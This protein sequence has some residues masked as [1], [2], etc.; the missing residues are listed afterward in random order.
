MSE[1]K[2]DCAFFQL[3]DD[4]KI[5]HDSATLCQC[6]GLMADS[7]KKIRE[8]CSRL[9]QAAEDEIANGEAMLIAMWIVE[10]VLVNRVKLPE[11]GAKPVTLELR[12]DIG[13]EKGL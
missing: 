4:V 5:E 12:Q 11:F 10:Q 1:M 9:K 2:R 3:P 6:L 8:K 7:T 13:C